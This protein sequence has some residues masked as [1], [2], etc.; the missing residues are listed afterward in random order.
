MKI[1][2]FALTALT[3]VLT[4]TSCG[5]ENP[6]PLFICGVTDPVLE[7]TWL[8]E[9]TQDVNNSQLSQFFYLVAGE[10]QGEQVFIAR[11]CCPNC[12]SVETVYS[13]SGQ[14]LGSFGFDILPSE[15]TREQV[16]WRGANFQC[17]V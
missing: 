14:E 3:I 15:I 10:Y 13:C 9:L 5:D 6:G 17:G 1:K 7:L 4:L 8:N 12:G 11:N 2:L 16:I